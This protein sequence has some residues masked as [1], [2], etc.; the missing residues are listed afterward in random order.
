M[1]RQY[2]GEVWDHLK[3]DGSGAMEFPVLAYLTCA[4]VFEAT[5]RQKAARRALK[6]GYQELVHR[7]DRVGDAD[8]RRSF[9]EQVPEHRR[10]VER[11]QQARGVQ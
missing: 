11:W 10:L 9:L 7:A 2:T 6:A 4:D 8:W 1:A 3:T 5:R